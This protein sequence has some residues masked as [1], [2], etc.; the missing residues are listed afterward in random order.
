M[1]S[2]PFND[3]NLIYRDISYYCLDLFEIICCEFVVYMYVKHV[4][5]PMN[6]IQ[7]FLSYNNSEADEFRYILS[8]NRKSL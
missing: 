7:L 2:I 3:D 5:F 8:K 4:P 1:F 6:M